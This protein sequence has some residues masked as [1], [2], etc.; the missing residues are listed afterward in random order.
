MDTRDLRPAGRRSEDPSRRITTA[1]SVL[2][3]AVLHGPEERFENS[4]R[5]LA[6]AVLGAGENDA[7]KGEQ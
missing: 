1:M 4:A 2:A 3:W 6:T 5:T 7:M